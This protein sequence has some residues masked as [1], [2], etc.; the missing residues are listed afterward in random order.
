MLD[1][2]D[3]AADGLQKGCPTALA[4]TL[5]AV[6]RLAARRGDADPAAARYGRR[7]ELAANARLG[8][9]PDFA[10]GVAC[11][12]GKRRGERPKWSNDASLVGAIARAVDGLGDEASL[13]DVVAGARG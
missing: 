2:L 4:V 7:V 3:A 11:V 12:V 10:E 13:G 5:D 6:D 8:G 9:A 1:V